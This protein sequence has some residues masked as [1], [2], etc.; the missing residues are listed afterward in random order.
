MLKAAN[1]DNSPSEFEEWAK[2]PVTSSSRVRLVAGKVGQ[3]FASDS[4][5]SSQYFID[6]LRIG[7]AAG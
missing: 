3:S 4:E 7:L 1:V 2:V 5:L 6:R